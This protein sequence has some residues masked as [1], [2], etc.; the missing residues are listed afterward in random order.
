M[1]GGFL[2]NRTSRALAGTAAVAVLAGIPATAQAAPVRG[3][4]AEW[5]LHFDG[6][7]GTPSPADAVSYWSGTCLVPG[8]IF[9]VVVLGEALSGFTEQ[10]P[11]TSQGTY[12]FGAMHYDYFKGD[13]R[14]ATGQK[15]EAAFMTD[16]SYGTATAVIE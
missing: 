14:V 1:E 10:V 6:L 9:N 15:Y 8:E 2:M 16:S 7:G 5:T 3:K 4:A 12:R 13:K 11:C